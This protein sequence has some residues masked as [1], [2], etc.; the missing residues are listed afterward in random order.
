MK[1]IPKNRTDASSVAVIIVHYGEQSLTERAIESVQKLNP[2]PGQIYVV[3]NGPSDWVCQP[4]SAVR[5]LDRTENSGYAGAVN[6]GAAAAKSAGFKF[7][8]ILNNDV[9]VDHSSI[10][11]F[12]QAYDDEPLVEILGSYVMQGD[13][14]WFGGGRISRRTGRAT[15]NNFGLPLEEMDATGHSPTD[16]VNGCSMF[17]PL[18]SFE[19]RGWFDEFFFLYKEELEWQLRAPL[20]RARVIHL[21]LV[22][23]Q[24]GATTGSTDGRLGRVFMARNGL[25]LATRQVGVHRAMWLSTWV[26]D[27][28][29]RPTLLLRWRELRDNMTGAASARTDPHA[30]L[31]KL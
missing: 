14:C 6:A 13:S 16:W 26:W 31:A 15:H 25:I 19:K 23:H 28:V 1:S 4:M 27:F 5:V 12:V 24:V 30:V 17:I 20:L 3:N 8:W 29:C 18:T 9:V 2:A 7:I 11:H 22:D 21:P 10:A